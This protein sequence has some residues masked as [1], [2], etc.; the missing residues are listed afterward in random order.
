MRSGRVESRRDSCK[1]LLMMLLT[2]SPLLVM[3]E[4]SRCLVPI[5]K[6]PR[7]AAGRRDSSRRRVANLVSDAGAPSQRRELRLLN[8][9][10]YVSSSRNINVGRPFGFRVH[11]VW[12]EASRHPMKQD[13]EP[14]ANRTIAG[15][16]FPT[17]Y[18]ARGY[19]AKRRSSDTGPPFK[20]R[21]DS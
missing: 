15:A 4:V 1:T 8:S 17:R 16:K 5:A 18:K 14:A 10:G 19:F 3:M 2:R 20:V 6:T 21:P 12:L 7:R 13:N 9:L 11:E